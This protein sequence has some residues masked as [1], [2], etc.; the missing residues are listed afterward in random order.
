MLFHR[1]LLE[2]VRYG[3]LEA[4][5]DEVQDAARSAHAHAFITSLPD[6]YDAL[7][8]ERG[9]RLRAGSGSASPLPAPCSRTRPFSSWT[10]RRRASTR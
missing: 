1:S 9:V 10:R 8:G 6:A 3:R 7:V 5:D 2:N 4:T